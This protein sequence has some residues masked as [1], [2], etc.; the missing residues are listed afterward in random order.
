MKASTNSIKIE[1]DGLLD[2]LLTSELAIYAQPVANDGVCVS[3]PEGGNTGP[4][5]VRRDMPSAEDYRHWVAMSDYN[6]I[7]FDGA[8]L[9]VTYMVEADSI[10]MHRLAYVP[11]PFAADPELLKVYPILDVLD[12]Y[13]ESPVSEVALRTSVRFD[14][15]ISTARPGHPAAHL[16]INTPNCRV[17]CAGPVCLGHFIDFVFRNFYPEHLAM[18]PYLTRLP[19]RNLGVPTLTDDQASRIH[20]F[21]RDKPAIAILPSTSKARD[22][23][24]GK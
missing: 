6:A 19:K 15:D 17:A 20:V 23:R 22:R 10:V 11:F 18:H 16:T 13:C 14:F 2:Y 4:F 21:W 9:Q 3:W 1:L 12:L 5:L 24:R 8:L 7:L